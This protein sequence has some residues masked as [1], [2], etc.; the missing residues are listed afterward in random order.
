MTT[1][2]QVE[3]AK[4]RINL[5]VEQGMRTDLN[6]I[7][8]LENGE[9]CFC[10]PMNLMGNIVGVIIPLSKNSDLLKITKDFVKKYNNKL[11]PYLVLS[12]NT[13][14]GQ[15]VTILYVSGNEDEWEYDKTEMNNKQVCAYS[16]FVEDQED[17]I[18]YI[19]YDIFEGGP[20]RTS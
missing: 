16:L 7:S 10:Q 5:L 9:I 20:I 14:Y 15:V 13:Q 12:M 4:K 19:G 8:M 6:L 11:F 1:S 17:E 2:K 18:G 3:E